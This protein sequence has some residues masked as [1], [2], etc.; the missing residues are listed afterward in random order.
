MYC[1]FFDKEIKDDSLYRQHCGKM[2]IEEKHH[3]ILPTQVT[4][5]DYENVWIDSNSVMYSPD[6]KRLLQVPSDLQV[7]FPRM[8]RQD[9]SPAIE[10]RW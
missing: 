2:L 5:E 3:E 8:G 7:V 9:Q 1:S 10:R 6:R 4:K